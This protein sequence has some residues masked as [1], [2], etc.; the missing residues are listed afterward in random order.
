VKGG[1]GVRGTFSTAFRAPAISELFS[2]AAD[3]FPGVTDP[4]DTSQGP[5]ATPEIDANCSA[6]GLPDDFTDPATQMRTRVGGNP[7][8]EPE[9]AGVFTAGIVYEP[10][11]VKGLSLTIDYFNIDIDNAIDRLGASVI[12]N[13]CYARGDADACALI[14]RDAAT[15][16]IT[17][18]DDRQTNIPGGNETSG[19]DFA[20]AYRH[21][22]MHTGRF[23]HQ[24]EG[25]W[26]HK[27]DFILDPDDPDSRVEGVGVYD[28]GV[29]PSWKLNLGTMWGRGPIGAGANVRFYNGYQECVD[30]DCIDRDGDGEP[31]NPSRDVDAY[32]TADLF[33]NYTLESLGGTTVVGFGVNNVLDQTPPFINQGFLGNSDASTYDFLGRYFY[34]RLNQQF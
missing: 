17:V 9:E 23:R 19:V 25:T 10:P 1:L 3:S 31:D 12:L 34:L 21:G 28:L 14:T 16:R 2:G 13:R 32:Y 33:A 7:D 30:N 8:L 4:C 11:F 6:A 24:V 27:Y 26:L 15:Q 5:R 18:I 22:N 20:I 29:F